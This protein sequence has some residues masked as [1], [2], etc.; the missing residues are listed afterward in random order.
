MS[1][2]AKI[3]ITIVVC[4]MFLGLTVVGLGVYWWTHHSHEV[5]EAVENQYQEGHDTGKKS[6]EQACVDEAVA[7]YKKNP[8]FTKGISAALFLRG[9]LDSSRPTPGFCEQV[10][11]R[12]DFLRS[13]RW[14]T[15]QAQKAGITDAF[16]KQ[17]FQQIQ[18]YC[19]SDHT[20]TRPQPSETASPENPR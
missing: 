20:K 13:A 17:M 9:C 19:E 7:R 3:I 14:Q 4:V 8:G 1:K 2:A 16:G 6:D 18:D 11:R 10:P 5:F 12:T 15:E